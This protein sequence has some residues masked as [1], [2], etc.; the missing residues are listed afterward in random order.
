[1]IQVQTG[2]L[3]VPGGTGVQ[4]I[5]GLCF[6]PI[7]VLFR[8]LDQTADG[9]SS[10]M[11]GSMGFS[12][13]TANFSVG[14]RSDHN[15][16]PT[17]NWGY[18]YPD[19]TKCISFASSNAAISGFNPNG[20]N[21]NWSAVGANNIVE[22]VAFGGDTCQAK[23]KMIN[24]T[25]TGSMSFTGYGFQGQLL[26]WLH[27]RGAPWDTEDVTRM[28]MDMGFASGSASDEQF[29]MHILSNSGASPSQSVHEY[30]T[31]KVDA[32][33]VTSFSSWDADGYTVSM[34]GNMGGANV[35][36]LVLG[37]S[38]ETS[39]KVTNDSQKTSTGTKAQTGIGFQ[40]G[41]LLAAGV[42][43]T[44]TT[45]T[46]NQANAYLTFGA[47]D[48]A[49]HECGWDGSTNG[50]N[51]TVTATRP[52]ESILISH[53]AP[54]STTNAEAPVSS[55][56]ADG[57]TLNWTTADATARVFGVVCFKCVDGNP[58][59]SFARFYATLV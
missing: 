33:G 20:F 5:T 37:D 51:P 17:G 1:M 3:L 50:V 48:S 40:P 4:T 30:F 47:Y 43:G 39:F 21:L 52:D 14:F 44:N 16:N 57:Y 13:G 12:D 46:I 27:A 24:P 58:C 15:V 31:G 34:T 54:A 10:N 41:A 35:A 26:M 59:P 8:A 55:L 7:A 56:D 19:T 11:F 18:T 28:S 32:W 6:E 45:G 23:V 53:S 29:S 42:C 25:G 2:R 49:T 38:A 9:Y 36:T 22:W